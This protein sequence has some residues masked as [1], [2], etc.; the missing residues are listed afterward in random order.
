[1]TSSNCLRSFKSTG[2]LAAALA[3]CALAVSCGG[4]GGSGSNNSN[5]SGSTVAQQ[6]ASCTANLP[7][8]AVPTTGNSVP[9]IVDAGPCAYGLPFGTTSGTSSVF[10]LGSANV[11]YTSVRICTPGTTSCQTID[12][13][14][15]DTGSTGLRIM[16]S[17]LS[18]SVSLPAV[19]TN[20]TTPLIECVQFADGY[21]W[22]SLR[23]ADV[24]LAGEVASGITVQ[25][26]GDATTYTVPPSC[27]SG[28][29]TALNDVISFGANGVLGI[30]LFAQ[31]CGSNCVSSQNSFYYSC[32]TTST[33]QESTA[34]LAQQATN[35]VAAF[36]DYSGVVLQFPAVSAGG[37]ALNLRGTLTFGINTQTDNQIATLAPSAGSYPADGYGDFISTLVSNTAGYALP[38]TPYPNSFID[39][40]SNGIYLPSGTI[41][42]TDSTSGWYTP[43]IAVSAQNPVADVFSLVAT[44]QGATGTGNSN[45]TINTYNFVIANANTVLF[46]LD[47]GTDTAFN[48]LGAVSSGTLSSSVGG[49]DWGLPFFFGRPLFV[50]LEGNPITVGNST[51]TGPFWAY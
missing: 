36:T 25:V 6:I 50:V 13:I 18:S 17:V 33:C 48:G 26:I 14:L 11:P 51:P 39:S 5:T 41:I 32:P 22:G 9:V 10:V 47:N 37:G 21:S 31:D 44:Q 15:V 43:T 2:L 30:G 38:T 42:P 7:T 35:P 3:L 27:T 29:S 4:G 34:T 8:L 23:S 28:G 24:R 20:G 49:I 12:H 16:S 1:M 46:P 19:T 45:S 40:G